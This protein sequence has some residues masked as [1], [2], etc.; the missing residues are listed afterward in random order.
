MKSVSVYNLLMKTDKL[1]KNIKITCTQ[2]S[3]MTEH[4]K[5]QLSCNNLHLNVH[6]HINTCL[7]F[8]FFY[9]LAFLLFGKNAPTEAIIHFVLQFWPQQQLAGN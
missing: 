4:E 1:L 5:L 3:F 9:F 8:F 6:F 7:L 2:L